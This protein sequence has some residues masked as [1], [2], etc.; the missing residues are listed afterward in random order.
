MRTISIWSVEISL[1][2]KLINICHLIVGSSVE[3]ISGSAVNGS[4]LIG[5]HIGVESGLVGEIFNCSADAVGLSVRIRTFDGARSVTRLLSGPSG[6]EFVAGLITIWIWSRLSQ[7]VL[8]NSSGQ[9]QWQELA[10]GHDD[11][12]EH[13]DNDLS[14]TLVI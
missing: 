13:A 8:T 11:Q 1:K 2:I 12:S 9:R 4:W 5:D 6:A 10:V 7:W 14:K 3:S